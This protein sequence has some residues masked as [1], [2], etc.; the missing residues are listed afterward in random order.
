MD[1]NRKKVLFI[2]IEGV[3]VESGNVMD[4]NFRRDVL[5]KIRHL[6]ISRVA[7]M[8]DDS[9]EKDYFTKIKTVEYFVF[10]YCKTAVSIHKNN[11]GVVG[12][13]MGMLPHNIR[14]KETFL[15]VGCKLDGI[16][17]LSLEDFLK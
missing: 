8:V 1:L 2:P 13:V 9:E 14:K 11:E 7:I 4:L 6:N 10:V 12:E 17:S 3:L 5:E 16:D 15:S